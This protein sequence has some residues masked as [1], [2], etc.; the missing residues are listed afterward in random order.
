MKI[1]KTIL[2]S[3]LFCLL[4]LQK[5]KANNIKEKLLSSNVFNSLEWHNLLHYN[6]GKSAINEDSTFFLSPDGYKNPKSEYVATVI[7]LFSDK[8]INNDS[9]FC[10]YPARVDF[11]LKH[12]E[13]DKRSI[14]QHKCSEYE[15]Y[16]QKVP[17]DDVSIIFASENNISPSTMLGHSFLKIDGNNKSH[18]FSYFAAFDK[19]NSFNFYT[20]VLTSGVDGMYILSPY[21][22]KSNEYINNEDRSLWEFKLKLT[23]KEKQYL[24]KHLWELKDKNIK[25]RFIFYNCNTAIINILKVANADFDTKNIKPF[26]TP[27]EYIQELHNNNKI[28]NIN[29]EPSK[30]HKLSILRYGLNYVGKAPK[31]TRISVSQ[32]L[33]NKVTNINFSPV[34]Q[35]LKDI[36]NAYFSDLESKIL[37]VSLRYDYNLRK[38]IFDKI[39]ILKMESIIDYQTTKSLSKYFRFGLEN[40]LFN[41]NTELK[42]VVEFGLG[43]SKKISSTSVYILPKIGYHYDKFSNY[44]I[45][46]QIGTIS[47]I[48]DNI[49]I[50]NSYEKY[51]NTK[52]NNIG[53]IDKY[54][55]YAGYKISQNNEIYFDFS[56]YNEAKH[57]T[58]A[59]LGVVLHF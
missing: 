54:N 29:I 51:F 18:S 27:V 35:D 24:K 45:A 6:N 4:L 49:K 12:N 44:Y 41:N 52:K 50:I 58:S 13:L 17:F 26:V 20:R 34:Y 25:Y 8:N 38:F 59:L 23:D 10:K 11:I 16:N 3:C 37:D 40:D 42:P 31:P 9:V 53:Y 14:P 30:S 19:M 5:A 57:H 21:Q 32:D 47:R 43:I 46:P 33:S 39:D 1:L 15:E 55:F 36:S 7:G 48:G 28:S 56:Y 22:E 2:I